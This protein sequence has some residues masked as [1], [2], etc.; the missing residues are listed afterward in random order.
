MLLSC[1][2]VNSS[3]KPGIK[4]ILT[5]NETEILSCILV[6]GFN[7]LNYVI[8]G[9][10]SGACVR[11]IVNLTRTPVSSVNADPVLRFLQKQTDTFLMHGVLES[12]KIKLSSLVNIFI[13]E[14]TAHYS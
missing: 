8:S 1:Y 5:P 10:P 13:R 7:S 3:S 11:R 14:C 9:G 2:H 4:C 12:L 6:W